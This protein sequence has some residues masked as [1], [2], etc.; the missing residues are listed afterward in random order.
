MVG[1]ASKRAGLGLWVYGF[2]GYRFMGLWLV[3][4]PVYGFTGLRVYGFTGLRVY[5]SFSFGVVG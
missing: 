1:L 4:L 2:M 5:L 3:G